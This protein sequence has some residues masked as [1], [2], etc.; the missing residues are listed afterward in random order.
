MVKVNF[1]TADGKSHPVDAEI[2]ATLMEVAIRNMVPGIEAECGG[3]CACATCHVYVDDAWLPAVG[4]HIEI[5]LNIASIGWNREN[6][7]LAFYAPL[8]SS[9]NTT[10]GEDERIIRNYGSLALIG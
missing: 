9:G 7:S 3:A 8:Q 10:H 1:V 5:N 6:V 2:G 4:M